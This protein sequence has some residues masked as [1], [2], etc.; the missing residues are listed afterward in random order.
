MPSLDLAVHH[1]CLS[2]ADLDAQQTWYQQALGL[3]EVVE[4][5]RLDEPTVRTVVLRSP[6]GVR[7]ELI[8]RAGS[9]RHRPFADPLDASS[10]QGFGHWAVSV[11]D[12]DQ[13]FASITAA[14]GTAVWPP[15]PAV[16]PG[17]RFAYVKDPEGNLI[18]LIQLPG[19]DA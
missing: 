18:E 17:A 2:V 14:G 9:V 4:Q 7:L 5:Y 19:D 11:R 15:A 6:G 1:T 13:A 12:L 10:S 8:E 3:T 16:Q